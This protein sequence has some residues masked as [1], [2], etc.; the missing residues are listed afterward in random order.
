MKKALKINPKDN[1]VVAV[2]K[3]EK[4]DRVSYDNLDGTVKE[5]TA[6]EDI[7][8]YHK[9][10]IKKIDGGSFVIKYGEHIGLA[11]NTIEEGSHVHL[12]NVID[13]RE[14]LKEKEEERLGK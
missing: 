7:P 14:N 2:E 1:V 12:Q 9:I 4:N 13:N 6:L 10:A 3:I 5:I 8:I 11:A